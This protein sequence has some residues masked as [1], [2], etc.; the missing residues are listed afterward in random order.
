MKLVEVDGLL[1]TLH[2]VKKC[3]PQVV[4]ISTGFYFILYTYSQDS[5]IP[6]KLTLQT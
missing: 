6:T 1:T 5:I 3:L 4:I 2:Q